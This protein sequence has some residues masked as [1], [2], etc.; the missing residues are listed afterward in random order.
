MSPV[1]GQAL[2]GDV[3]VPRVGKVHP[4]RVRGVGRP[5]VATRA[6]VDD[7]GPVKD[8]LCIRRMRRVANGAIAF[9]NR[10]M[11]YR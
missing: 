2:N 8:K 11:H 7:R 10:L 6:Y 9:S 1:A 5:V 4:Y 3:P